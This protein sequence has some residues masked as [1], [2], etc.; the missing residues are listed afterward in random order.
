VEIVRAP[1]PLDE[2]LIEPR[3]SD[4]TSTLYDLI[5]N[6]RISARPERAKRPPERAAAL[7]R[8]DIDSI[9]ETLHRE[10]IGQRA[11]VEMIVA[12]M[13]ALAAGT[14]PNLRAPM[15]FL[16]IG[17]TG[18]GKTEMAKLTASSLDLPVY[19]IDM[20]NYK[21]EEGI[22]NLLGS[23]QGYVG[24]PGLL[25]S[26]VKSNPNAVL[27]FDEMEKADAAMFDP[28]LTL[29]DEGRLTDRRTDETI[30]FSK[31]IIFFTSNLVTDL[32]KN[33]SFKQNDLKDRVDA[34]GRLRREFVGRIQRI[35]PFVQFSTQEIEIICRLQLE[36]YLT[37]I[38]SNRGTGAAV[39]IADEVVSFITSQVDTRFGAR[40]VRD[41]IDQQVTPKLTDAFLMHQG[42]ISLIEIRGEGQG[43]EIIVE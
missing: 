10:I 15:N 43:I 40:N 17:P 4:R 24:G 28:L 35:V 36:A 32:P 5:R 22:W 3:S 26:Y 8:E 33:V 41:I 12:G 21:G 7:M 13:K 9:A 27:L 30:D 6:A 34:T 18:T 16:M 19:R 38:A 42:E 1:S 37:Q 20:P 23:P 39:R 25:T 31:T 29:L 2:S 11:A 14:R